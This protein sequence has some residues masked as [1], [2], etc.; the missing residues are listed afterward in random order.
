[1]KKKKRILKVETRIFLYWSL[2]FWLEYS[3]AHFYTVS[4]RQ[5]TRHYSLLWGDESASAK[6]GCSVIH[7]QLEKK[8]KIF[9]EKFIFVTKTFINSYVWL[10]PSWKSTKH[11]GRAFQTVLGAPSTFT[12]SKVA[13]MGEQWLRKLE[14]V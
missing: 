12:D 11:T 10:I 9:I 4:A 2:S 3:R 14:A 5:L 7:W 6:K 8:G 13:S 1:M